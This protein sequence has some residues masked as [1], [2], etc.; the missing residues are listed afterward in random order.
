V[1]VFGNI[2]IMAA[3][4]LLAALAACKPP[5]L[6][7][8]DAAYCEEKEGFPRGTDKNAQ[9]ALDRAD[10][11]EQAGVVR[12][13]PQPTPIAF[14]PGVLPPPVHPGGI[15]QVVPRTLVPE[16]VATIDFAVALKPDCSI[17]NPPQV[18]IIK[19][20]AHGI[21]TL[22]ERTDYPRFSLSATPAACVAD[23]VQ[24]IALEYTPNKEFLGSDLIEF[25]VSYK[26]GK[27]DLFRIPITVKKP[28]FV[29]P[30]KSG[31]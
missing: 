15:P 24:G 27:D 23:K 20:P 30:I 6:N 19:Q 22:T 2:L 13:P 28:R 29:T 17:D 10:A 5:I 16:R 21:A 11:L 14:P 3:A 4:A 8:E 26:G 31:Q 9:C 12:P 25:E 1:K 7:G 18:K